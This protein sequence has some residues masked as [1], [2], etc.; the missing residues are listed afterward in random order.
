MDMKIYPLRG[1]NNIEFGM[2]AK[3]VRNNIGKEFKEFRRGSEVYPSDYFEKEGIFCYYDSEGRL[4]AMEF[5]RPAR[6]FLGGVNLLSLHFNQIMAFLSKLDSR[7]LT[8]GDGADF[9][10]ISIGVYAPGALDEDE[11]DVPVEAILVGRENY[12]DFLDEPN[13]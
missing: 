11:G 1:V 5:H 4:D 3:F 8:D 13:T 10:T 2:H 9:R 12:Y 7:F 6:V